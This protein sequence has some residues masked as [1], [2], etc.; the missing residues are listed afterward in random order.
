MDN[1]YSHEAR[2]FAAA[3]H[4]AVGQKRKYTDEDYIVHPIEV[5]QIIKDYASEWA[6]DHVLATALLHDVLEDTKVTREQLAQYFPSEIIRYVVDLTDVSKSSDG[7]RSVRKEID[8]KHLANGGGIVH[9]VKL[10]DLISNSRSIIKY[11]PGFAPK[12]IGEKKAL[13]HVLVHGAKSL[14]D[15]AWDIINQYEKEKV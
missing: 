13:M 4:A 15:M 10:A 5:A 2:I 1:K 11:D 8:R 9:T 6:I 14:R 3:A 7:N 12:Y